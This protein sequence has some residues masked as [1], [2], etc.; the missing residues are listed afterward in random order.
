M[1]V[2]TDRLILGRTSEVPP[3]TARELAA[4]TVLALPITLNNWI[5]KARTGSSGRP[6]PLVQRH[7]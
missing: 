5:Y 1:R 2:L 7:G 3:S 4:T 6:D